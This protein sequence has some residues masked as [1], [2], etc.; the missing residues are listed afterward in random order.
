ML[1]FIIIIINCTNKDIIIINSALILLI[2]VEVFYFAL[3]TKL[4]NIN[5]KNITT[6]QLK[7][8]VHG[9]LKQ[10]YE[11]LLKDGAKNKTNAIKYN[12]SPSEISALWTVI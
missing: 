9:K 10:L 6:K 12:V 11:D 3:L 8:L 7:K 5:A 4:I 1:Y 2:C